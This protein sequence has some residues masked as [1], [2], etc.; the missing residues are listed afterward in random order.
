MCSLR[1]KRGCR[2]LQI[3]SNFNNFYSDK[4]DE[5]TILWCKISSGFCT[6]KLIKIGSFLAKSFKI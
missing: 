2:H 4:V 3:C 6:P 1:D 5:F